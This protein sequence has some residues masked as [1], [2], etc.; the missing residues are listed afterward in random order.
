VNTRRYALSG[1]RICRA[2]ERE[3][4]SGLATPGGV[5]NECRR[6]ANSGH[7]QLGNIVCQKFGFGTAIYVAMQGHRWIAV[8]RPMQP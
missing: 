2:S 4:A 8:L 3:F 6:G 7:F 5:F 1:R